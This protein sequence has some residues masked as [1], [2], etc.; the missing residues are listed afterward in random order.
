MTYQGSWPTSSIARRGATPGEL[1]AIGASVSG[2][3]GGFLLGL[4]SQPASAALALHALRVAKT[5]NPF[6]GPGCT[7]FDPMWS[8]S[9]RSYR[10]G[11]PLPSED[12]IAGKFPDFATGWSR[13]TLHSYESFA[14]RRT[15]CCW[16]LTHP[17]PFINVY[18]IWAGVTP[19]EGASSQVLSSQVVTDGLNNDALEL[20]H[21]SRTNFCE[22]LSSKC[23]CE[24]QL[25]S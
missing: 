21:V 25:N 23:K 22:V 17:C 11:T 8:P 6:R 12:P 5:G 3:E 9:A 20:K 2:E 10:C 13:R 4:C 14:G 1:V 7:F 16:D 15:I 18:R 24:H 19:S